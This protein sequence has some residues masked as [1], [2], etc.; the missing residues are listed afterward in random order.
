M[1]YK[2]VIPAYIQ[3]K[4]DIIDKIRDGIWEENQKIPSEQKLMEY[5]NVGRGTVRGAIK[6]V[7]DE[8]YVYIKKGIGTFVT[9]KDVG[10]AVEPFVS[11]TYFIKMRGLQITTTVL[12]QKEIIVDCELEKVTGLVAG[13]KVQFV[14]RLRILEGTPIGIEEFYF[15]EYANKYMKGYDFTNPISHYL[16]E[17]KKICVN[18][19][20]M[21]FDILEAK[22]EYKELLKLNDKNMIKTTRRV[23]TSPSNEILYYLEFY[24]GEKLS[25]IG[26]DNFL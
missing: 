18:H 1:E 23:H 8:G 21:A 13:S 2:S 17:E 10:I 19:M 9:Q 7:V 5:Y 24:C 12:E 25:H 6:L 22:G 15:S 4:D 14:K 20:E 3:I 16:F 26:R 11:L